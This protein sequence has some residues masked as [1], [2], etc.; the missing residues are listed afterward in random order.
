MDQVVITIAR[1]YGSGGRTVG[2]M[3]AERLGISFYD[4]Q[5]IQMASD[6]SGINEALFG[7]V[8]EKLKKSPLFRIVKR[9]YRGEI[10]PPESG[11]FVSD[12]NLFNYQAKVIRQL[13]EAESCVIIGRCADYVLK[14][15]DHVISLFF[16]A[17][18]EDCIRRV[19]EISSE[20]EK[21]II[22]KIEKTDKYRAEY[23]RYYTG[24]EWNDARNYDF[25]L[26]TTSMS[27]E[28]LVEVVKS[29]IDTYHFPANITNTSN[30][31]GPYQFP[32][33]LI[34]LIIN[35][36]LH[37]KKLPVYGDGMNIR[38]WLYVDDHAKGIDMVQE[39]GKLGESYNI[40]GHNE[41]R[42]IE[43]INIIIETLQEILP[44]TDPRKANVSKD[45]IT[46]VE[47][48]KG[49][50]RRY[51]IAPDKIKAEIGW[52]P[53]TMFK[54]GIKKTIAWYLEHEDW[55]NNVTSGDYQKYYEDMYQGK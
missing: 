49:H 41:K 29:Y 30:N 19:Q 11:E 17:P 9:T 6:E 33:K 35:N 27:Y 20:P 5:I 24:K 4:K 39:H 1:Q 2:K 51:A 12:D 53:E 38:D 21:E 14:E 15:F 16:Y 36:A 13:A 8:D 37:G 45:L 46:Y 54:D 42:N 23:Y 3:L 22:K 10:I 52:E 44:D 43:I 40:G 32:E 47:D 28:K 26:N 34:P 48:R 50:D 7:E 25:C 55:M 31:Y 18:R